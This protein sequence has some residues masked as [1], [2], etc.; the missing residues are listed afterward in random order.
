MPRTSNEPT[1][2]G[3]QEIAPDPLYAQAVAVVMIN[4]KASIGLVQRHLKLGYNH[5]ARLL[6]AMEQAGLIGSR[7]VNG[8]RQI[9]DCGIR[10]T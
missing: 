6:E 10:E 5:A 2:P 9:L 7:Y 1:E 3:A 8:Y 4:Q